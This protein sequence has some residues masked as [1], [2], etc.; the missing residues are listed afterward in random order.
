MSKKTCVYCGAVLKGRSDKQ[1]C[2]DQCRSAKNRTDNKSTEAGRRVARALRRNRDILLKVNPSGSKRV[3]IADLIE[4]GYQ[5]EFF[6]FL[7]S[8]E[9]GVYFGV[10]ETVIVPV[11][12]QYWQLTRINTLV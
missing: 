9:S 8:G 5:P 4:Q 7:R 3:L 12:S 10:Y 11:D 1:S 2:D 6:T